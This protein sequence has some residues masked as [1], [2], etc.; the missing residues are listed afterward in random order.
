MTICSP[1]L[2]FG[3][4]HG[5]LD[6]AFKK[7]LSKLSEAQEACEK[8]GDRGSGPVASCTHGIGHG[9]A[10]YFKSADLTGALKTCDALP[11]NSP[12]YCYDGVF[13][14][15]ARDS[16]DSFFRPNDPLYPCNAI[17]AKYTYACG[18]NLPAVLMDRFQKSFEDVAKIC[19]KSKSSSLTSSCYTALGFQA[20]R[21]ST[22]GIDKVITLCE[23]LS[24]KNFQYQCKSAAAGDLIFQNI[25]GWKTD[26]P[27]ICDTLEKPQSTSCLTH[28]QRIQ[29]SY[30]R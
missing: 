23:T 6:Q 20:A 27:A 7:D 2:A 18:R 29:T 11:E 5:L 21:S 4:Y 30:R 22:D 17:D 12:Q 15:F 1:V 28:V 9:V 13:M 19:E 26:S 10:S 16:L 14:E 25:A 3:C 24:D 8:L